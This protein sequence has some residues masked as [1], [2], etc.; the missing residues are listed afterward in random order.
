MTNCQTILTKR[1]GLPVLLVG[2]IIAGWT[3]IGIAQTEAETSEH[4]KAIAERINRAVEKQVQYYQELSEKLQA[5]QFDLRTQVR[6]TCGLS[7]ENVVPMLLSLEKERFT[8]QVEHKLKTARREMLAKLIAEENAKAGQ[9]IDSDEVTEQIKKIIVARKQLLVV[10]K[11]RFN[12]GL[13][14]SGAGQVNSAEAELAEAEL[15]LA[16][17]KQELAKARAEA[18]GSELAGQLRVLSLECAQDEMRLE[19]LGER[20]ATLGKVE[21]VLDRYKAASDIELPRVLRLL[22]QA[23]TQKGQIEL[24]TLAPQ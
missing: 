14:N 15:R 4:Q 12:Q 2:L 6:N 19:I 24:N 9:A 10:Q 1:R 7:P 22:E 17:R 21:S 20:L 18:G 11:E 23:Q 3:T 5:K 13:Q 8:L 16:M